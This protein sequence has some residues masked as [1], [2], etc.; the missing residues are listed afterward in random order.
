MPERERFKGH[1]TSMTK[2][3]LVCWVVDGR[4][5]VFAID[6]AKHPLL[7]RLIDARASGKAFNICKRQGK[8]M[9]D[10]EDEIDNMSN[11]IKRYHFGPVR[12]FFGYNPKDEP[13]MMLDT[14]VNNHTITI[15]IVGRD[16]LEKFHVV[17]GQM[18]AERG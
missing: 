9:Y 3:G 4:T 18:L 7:R 17:L 11:P 10:V 12:G 8:R 2:D 5:Y 13:T 1:M 16:Q 6:A 15:Q 14:Q